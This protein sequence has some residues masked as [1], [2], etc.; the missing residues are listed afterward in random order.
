MPVS[1]E[2]GYCGTKKQR[3]LDRKSTQPT[4]EFK[5]IT[6]EGEERGLSARLSIFMYKTTSVDIRNPGDYREDILL[7]FLPR[8]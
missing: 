5:R 8:E 4:F 6:L 2:V 1:F 7:F 3:V